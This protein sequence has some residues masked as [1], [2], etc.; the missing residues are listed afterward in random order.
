MEAHRSLWWVHAITAFAFIGYF[1][2]GKFGHVVY[3]GS[4]IFLRN[5]GLTGKLTHPDIDVLVEEDEE[6]LDRLGVGSVEGFSWKGLMDLDACVNCGRCEAMCPATISGSPL[7]P[8]KLIQDM[9]GQLTRSAPVAEAD[10]A[11]SA[12]IPLISPLIGDGEGRNPRSWRRNCGGAA[13]VAPACTSAPCSSSISP[14][15]SICDG[16]S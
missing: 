1:V 3:G 5:L 16:T 10:G 9:K 8:R 13:P 14:R 4:N 7:S 15:L 12:E 2:F 6:A 11:A